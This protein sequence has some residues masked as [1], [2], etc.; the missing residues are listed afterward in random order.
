MRVF[1]ALIFLPVA[2]ALHVVA[3]DF[4]PT[5]SGSSA[6]GGAGADSVTLAAATASQSAMI[7]KWQETP[8]VT[9]TGPTAMQAPA[10]R[11]VRILPLPLSAPAPRIP[12]LAQTP[13]MTAPTPVRLPQ[14]DT[15]TATP[16]RAEPPA[17]LLRPK[18]RTQTAPVQ[19]QPAKKAGGT[20]QNTQRGEAAAATVQSQSTASAQVLKAKWGTA[21]YT[22]VQ[23]NMR[24]PRS[25]NAG[26]TAKLALQVAR[27][28]TLQELK[29][30]RS[31]GNNA[32]DAAALRA[33]QRAGRFAA[34]PKGLD[35]DAYGFSLSLTFKR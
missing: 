23:R 20:G 28:G 11:S 25:L 34:A 15:Q 35:A 2:A 10:P 29:L 18:A 8:Q 9:A 26:G 6:A 24:F 32:V 7:A 1:E 13:P 22:K 17:P 31:S 27:N 14:M 12:M 3:W 30:I 16:A 33:V 21:I 4:A 5:S 19:P